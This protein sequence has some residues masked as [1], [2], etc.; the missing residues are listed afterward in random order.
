MK[1][2]LA[3]ALVVLGALVWFRT[4]RRWGSAARGNLLALLVFVAM[5]GGMFALILL[6]AR[7]F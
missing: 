7:L 3:A 5:L 4:A 1:L 6:A 2:W